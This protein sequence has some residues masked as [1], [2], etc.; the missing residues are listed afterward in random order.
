MIHN[1]EVV[2]SLPTHATL[3]IKELQR[4]LQL[5]FALYTNT[6]RTRIGSVTAMIR[7]LYH[8]IFL[9]SPRY[10]NMPFNTPLNVP[11]NVSL[12]PLNPPLNPPLLDNGAL[13]RIVRLTNGS[14]TSKVG[15]GSPAALQ[16]SMMSVM[17][18]P[19]VSMSPRR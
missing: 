10:H 19:H 1:P 4:N 15:S 16:P 7:F 2:G 9:L 13:K 12:V 18:R 3:K 8:H 5:L 14:A 11:F 17:P 6:G